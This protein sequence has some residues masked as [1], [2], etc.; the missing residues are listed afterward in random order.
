MISALGFEVRVDPS[1][2]CFLDSSTVCNGF[3]RFT[4]G[5]TPTGF[6]MACIATEPFLSMC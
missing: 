2:V 4:S 1:L 6:L 5:V 3:V